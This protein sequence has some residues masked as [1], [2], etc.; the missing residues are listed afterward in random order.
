V[1]DLLGSFNGPSEKSLRWSK[2]PLTLLSRSSGPENEEGIAS[3]PAPPIKR[4]EWADHPIREMVSKTQR[5]QGRMHASRASRPNTESY[6]E[7]AGVTIVHRHSDRAVSQAW[8]SR[9]I[10]VRSVTFTSRGQG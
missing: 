9:H 5:F 4:S 7:D 6:Y 2:K 3:V 10:Q 8:R 1:F